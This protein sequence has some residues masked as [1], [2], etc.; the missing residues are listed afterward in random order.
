MY[1]YDLTSTYFE[2][3]C[4]GNPQAKR[5]YSRDQR[6]D[7]KQVVGLVLDGEGFPQAHEVFD[8]NRSDAST[9]GEMLS[10]LEQRVGLRPG[11]T[12]VVD[13]GM[14]GAANLREIQAR[15]YHYI[16]ASR[17]GERAA[18]WADFEEGSEWDE[19]VRTPSP[20]NP[21]QKKTRVQVKRRVVGQ[22]VHILCRSEGREKKDRAILEKHEGRLV[23]DLK[24]LEARI[25]SGRLV[26][27]GKIQQAIGRLRERYSRVARYYDIGY[28][29][30]AK[31]LRWSEDVAGKAKARELDGA[32]MLKT[33]RGDLT[34][35]EIWRTYMLLTR[36]ESAF[37]SMKSP[38]MERPIWH[39][40][41]HRVQT[42]IFLCVLACHLL[43]AV[44]K[45]CLDSGWHT[46]WA[47][48]REQLSTHQVVTVVLPT[49]TGATLRIRT[50]TR[51]EAKHRAIYETLQ[52]PAEVMRPVRTWSKP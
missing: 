4:L 39:Q 22:E 43:V 38:L 20:L 45:M 48:L 11:A 44:E 3:Q 40:L 28:D 12:V 37:R 49:A 6:P 10:S 13:R 17:Q 2:G 35:E 47:T 51:P 7:C 34:A 26:D 27:E 15:G 41:Q 1:L 31:A 24:R 19:V 42:H 33:G 23:G 50:G 46:S 36:V 8:G 30:G 14:A 18:H 9:V 21:G 25:A 29:A 5:G 16:V 52:I 32:Y